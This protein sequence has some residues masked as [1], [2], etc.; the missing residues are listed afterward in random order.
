VAT[1]APGK[2]DDSG[3]RPIR[4]R[5]GYGAAVGGTA[6]GVRHRDL[7]TGQRP[8]SAPSRA[9]GLPGGGHP[10]RQHDYSS[11]GTIDLA[12]IWIWL[13][14]PSHDPQDRL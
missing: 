7:Q 6:A 14:D 5:T 8:W 3:I 4:R 10:L 1:P 2:G 12:S 13:R 11:R 9:H